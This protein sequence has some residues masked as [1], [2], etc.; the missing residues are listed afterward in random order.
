MRRRLLATVT[1][2][3]F[4]ILTWWTLADIHQLTGL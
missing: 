3:G 2:T 1:L 4:V